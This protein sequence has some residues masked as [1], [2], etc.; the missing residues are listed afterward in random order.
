MNILRSFLPLLLLLLCVAAP[1]YLHAAVNNEGKLAQIQQEKQKLEK[2]RKQLEFRLGA[3]GQELRKLDKALVSARSARREVDDKIDETDKKITRLRQSKKHLNADINRME[4]KMIQQATAAYQRASREPGWLDVFAGVSVSE[5]PHRKKM[6][7]FAMLSQEKDRKLWQKKVAELV[8]VEKEEGAK[9]RE[10]AKL[11]KERAKHEQEV[12]LRVDAKRTMA[13]RVRK[14]V[15]LNKEREKQLVAQE[16]A[17]K[18][19]IEGLS[20]GLLGSDKLAKPKSVQKQKGRLPWPIRG[21][22]VASFGSRPVPGRPKLTGVQLIPT[23]KNEKGKVVKAIAGGQVRYADWFGGYGLMMIVDHGDGLISVYA[24]N[25]ALYWQMGDWVE[26]GER[27][28]EAGS[29]GWIE[30]VRLYFEMRE[31]GKPVNPKKWCRR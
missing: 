25:D 3:L 7:Q 1:S 21:K 11:Q 5:I 2:I 26:A 4:E 6:L 27:L 24:H 9:R 30:D 31:N 12:A 13:E 23:S 28:A 16:K 8:A 10:L 14:D 18:R 29:T 20:E 15:G 19:L 17:L 22:V